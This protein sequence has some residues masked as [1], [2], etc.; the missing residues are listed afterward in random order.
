MHAHTQRA[1]WC[2]L[3][4]GHEPIGS[5]P[6]LH[7]TLVTSIK[8]VSLNIVVWEDRD[9]GMNLGGN[10]KVQ[11]LKGFRKYKRGSITYP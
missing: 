7:V 1:L 2:P 11:H 5:K 6:Y 8:A 10:S 3:L 4:S 9:Q